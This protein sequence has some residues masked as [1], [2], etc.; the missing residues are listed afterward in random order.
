VAQARGRE[1]L[2]R[3]ELTDAA[4][5]PAKTYSGGMRRRLDP[6]RRARREAA[7]IYLDEPTTDSTRAAGSGCGG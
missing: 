7:V 1:L 5:R 2:E 3:F 4:N 6:G